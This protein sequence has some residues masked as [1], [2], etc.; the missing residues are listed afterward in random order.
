MIAHIVCQDGNYG[1]HCLEVCSCKSDRFFCNNTLGCVCR[2]GFTGDDCSIRNG[3]SLRQE[4]S[5][6]G[7]ES[8]VW[9]IVTIV[10]II[11]IIMVAVYCT[12]IRNFETIDG[13]VDLN[14]TS[15][16]IQNPAYGHI[17]IC[18]TSNS[19]QRSKPLPPRPVDLGIF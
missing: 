8:A 11:V 15:E 3:S 1:L 10:S 7:V 4:R 2:E 9:M 6:A 19:C 17:D 18:T 16:T 14:G 12:R 5:E 13:N